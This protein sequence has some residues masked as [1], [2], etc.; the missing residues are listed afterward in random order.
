MSICL[1]RPPQNWYLRL[2]KSQSCFEINFWDFSF[3][4]QFGPP[5]RASGNRCRARRE[6]LYRF[7]DFCLKADA[8][9]SGSKDGP[10]SGS[11]DEPASG[12]WDVSTSGGA[13]GPASG[14]ASGCQDGPASGS[15]SGCQDEHAS[16]SALGCQDRPASGR[17]GGRPAAAVAA[18]SA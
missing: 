2:E 15:V 14:S 11:K 18:A 4:V 16:G 9:A 5:P 6:Q 3:R 13:T 7:D 8:P 17:R 12:I 10:A 1:P